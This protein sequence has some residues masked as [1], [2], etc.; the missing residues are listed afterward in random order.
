MNKLV[1]GG[2]LHWPFP[3]LI[4]GSLV[5]ATALNFS[6]MGSRYYGELV[7]E[8]TESNNNTCGENEATPGWKKST[9]FRPVN[10]QV[11]NC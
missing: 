7:G 9:I 2:Q 3:F 11:P 4:E 8:T 5:K 1:Q 6:L 10:T